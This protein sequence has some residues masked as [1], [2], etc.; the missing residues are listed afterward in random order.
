[1]KF[2][3]PIVDDFENY[4][5]VILMTC[6][7]FVLFVQVVARYLFGT[8]VDWS[9]EL[10]RFLFVWLV[11]WSISYTSMLGGQIRVTIFL[12][13]L[14]P[15]VRSIVFLAGEFLWVMFNTLVIY[16]GFNLVIS[17]LQFP[18]V[19][20]TIR[21]NMAW[22]YTAVPLGFLFCTAR[23]LQWHFANQGVKREEYLKGDMV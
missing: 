5:C 22:I 16:E 12:K 23:V 4:L 8:G 6:M 13:A 11:I 18:E 15:K 10:S 20:P 2:L 17:T 9:E 1:M 19:S 7:V 21:I 14:P 3:K